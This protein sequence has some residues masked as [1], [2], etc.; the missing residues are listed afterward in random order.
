MTYTVHAV[1]RALALLELLAEARELGVTEIAERTGQTK[2]L[3]FRLL[4]TLEQRGYVHKDPT[5]RTYSLGYRPLYL[6]HQ[7]RHHSQLI[8]TAEIHLDHLAEVTQENVLL[9]VREELTC[10]CIAMRQSPQPLRL[11]AEVGK[12]GPLHAG[13]GPKVLLAYAPKTVR[14]TVLA[15]DLQGFTATSI[16]DPAKLEQALERICRDGWTISL[17]ELD[18]SAFSIAAPIR[19]HTNSVV[20]ALSIAGPMSRLDDHRRELYRDQLLDAA[21]TLSQ[22]LGYRQPLSRSA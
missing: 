13:G 11:F 15:S 14:D 6:A 2:S 19:D 3:V 1:D 21:A 5:R 12:A 22:G 16:Q 4:Y 18:P 17:G 20:A 8:S 9:V 10:V 7:T